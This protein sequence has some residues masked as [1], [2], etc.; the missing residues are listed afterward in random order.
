[1]TKPE[2][3]E[4]AL[5]I[6]LTVE[7]TSRI[8]L[9]LDVGKLMEENIAKL[10]GPQVFVEQEPKIKAVRVKKTHPRKSRLCR[11]TQKLYSMES[12]NAPEKSL[13]IELDLYQMETC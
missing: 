11:A 10:R 7:E 12:G 2:P 1:M 9:E 5:K 13:N 3:V 4:S 8:G 6:P